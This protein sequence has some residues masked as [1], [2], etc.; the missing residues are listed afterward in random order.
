VV[1]K[2]ASAKAMQI[3][4]ISGSWQIEWTGGIAAGPLG[5][6]WGMPV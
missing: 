2:P 4:F 6:P 1:S 5:H 3:F